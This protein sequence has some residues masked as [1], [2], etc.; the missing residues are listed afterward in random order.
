MKKQQSW[1]LVCLITSVTVLI[2][3]CWG[4]RAITAIA[5]ITPLER[6]QCIVIDAGHGGEDGGAT[7]CCGI[8]EST[9][10]LEI[11]LRLRDLFQLL[12]YDTL[13]TRTTDISIYTK[14]NTLSQKKMSDLKERVRI[15]NEAENAILISIHQN[16]F[17]DSQYSGAQ[18]FYADTEKSDVLAK[19]VQTAFA[20]TLNPGSRRQCKKGSGIYLMDHIIRPGILIECGFL[21]NPREE[22]LLRSKEYQKKLCCVIVSAVDGFLS[23]T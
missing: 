16:M 14:G 19:A 9:Y 17:P 13:M 21:S 8:L 7:S 11:A 12:G 4:S 10:N 1:I 20:E 2:V 23:N 6:E 5:Q 15:T 18:V 22:A 3:A